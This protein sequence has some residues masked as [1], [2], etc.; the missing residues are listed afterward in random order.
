MTS[1]QSFLGNLEV[2]VFLGTDAYDLADYRPE[3]FTWKA[4]EDW[5]SIPNRPEDLEW[6]E[7][8]ALPADCR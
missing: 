2:F 8:K 7:W 3:I 1:R 5:I 6:A 4:G